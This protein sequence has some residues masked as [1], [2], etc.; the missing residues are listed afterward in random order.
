MSSTR[1]P[2]PRGNLIFKDV[3]SDGDDCDSHVDE[4]EQDEEGKD[5]SGEAHERDKRQRRS[6]GVRMC[7]S[8]SVP[9]AEQRLQGCC[10]YKLDDRP[11][12]STACPCAVGEVLAG[13]LA[14]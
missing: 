9:D 11:V 6:R 1:R 10:S 8:W 13:S 12:G 14:G 2:N 3:T 4:G 5:A 7:V